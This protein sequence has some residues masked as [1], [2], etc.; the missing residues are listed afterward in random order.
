MIGYYVTIVRGQRVGYLFGPYDKERDARADIPRARVL[1]YEIDPF[2]C[3]DAFGTGRVEAPTLP[4]GV[5][6]SRK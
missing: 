3:F 1:A 2:A 5:L 6:E 4:T